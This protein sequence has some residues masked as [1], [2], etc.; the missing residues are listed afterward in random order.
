[1]G[2]TRSVHRLRSVIVFLS[3]GV[4]LQ[5]NGQNLGILICTY[6]NLLYN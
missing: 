3:V 1:M 6:L 2:T 5:C 4:I